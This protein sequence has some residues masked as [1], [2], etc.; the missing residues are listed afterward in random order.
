M[1]KMILLADED[2]RFVERSRTV[3]EE[4]GYEVRVVASGRVSV[5]QALR[6]RPDLIVLKMLSQGELV[7]FDISRELRNCEHTRSIP[8]VVITSEGE[9]PY[10]V[11]PDKTWL[12]V[13]ALIARPV[14]PETLLGVVNRVLKGAKA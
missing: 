9:T 7:G 4:H 12:P 10:A 1:A 5:E 14:E 11:E 13:D 3:L 6:E 2:V 8:L